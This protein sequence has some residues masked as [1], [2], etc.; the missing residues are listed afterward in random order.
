MMFKR[1]L[2]L[3]LLITIGLS[4]KAQQFS[5]FTD[6]DSARAAYKKKNFQQA[7]AYYEKAFK[8]NGN[9]SVQEEFYNAACTWSL[10]GKPDKAFKYL[11][12]IIQDHKNLIRSWNDPGEFYNMLVKDADFENLRKL[13]KWEKLLAQAKTKKE[14]F[15]ANLNQDLSRQ[16]QLMEENDQTERLK[17]DKIRKEKGSNSAEEKDLWKVI[18]RQDSIN[19]AKAKNLISTYGWLSPQQVGYKGN[20]GLFLIIQ[21]ADLTTQQTYLPI[22][23]KAAAEGKVAAWSLAFLEDRILMREKKRQIYGSQLYQ[24]YLFPVQDLDN[25]DKRRASVGL[26]PIAEYLEDPQKKW[27]IETYKK[28]LPELIKKFAVKD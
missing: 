27:N 18:K 11:E 28:E 1:I 6:L 20:Q 8:A 23:R 24:N 26:E 9:K 17:L 4:S 12:D 19:L 13:P 22:V 21:H 14:K 15:E 3:S 16:L 25:L 2:L 5:Y 7:A 10:A